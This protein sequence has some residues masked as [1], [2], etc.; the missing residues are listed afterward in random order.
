MI[1]FFASAALIVLA[2]AISVPVFAQ[3]ASVQEKRPSVAAGAQAQGA[4]VPT[5]VN[6]VTESANRLQAAVDRFGAAMAGAE[7]QD[8]GMKAL[9]EMLEAARSVNESLNRDS[10]I[11][12]ELN[13]LI[14]QWTGKRNSVNAR[15]RNNPALLPLAALWQEKVDRVIDLRTS[16]LDQATDSELLIRDVENKKEV[17]AEYYQLDAIDQVLAEM[18]VMNDELTSMNESMRMILEKTGGL[19]EAQVPTTN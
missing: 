6:G 2:T 17:I 5:L 14:D 19:E 8:A 16:I 10:K 4:G 13:G 1:K 9:D 18:Q 12:T 11:W 7:D 15:A 3:N